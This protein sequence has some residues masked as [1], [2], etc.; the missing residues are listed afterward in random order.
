MQNR[1]KSFAVLAV[2]VLFLMGV[3]EVAGRVLPIQMGFGG[4]IKYLRFHSVLGSELDSNLEVLNHSNSCVDIKAI[5]I[6]QAGMRSA[7]EYSLVPI[8][9]GPRIALLGDSF[10][11]GREVSDGEEAAAAISR[12]LLE[13]DALNF[14]VPGYGSIQQLY[15]YELKARNYSPDIVVLAFLEVNDVED[16]SDIITAAAGWGS[17]RPMF[18]TEGE[19]I[20]PDPN[21]WSLMMG[22]SSGGDLHY[23]L[24][25]YSYIYFIL[26]KV[27]MRVRRVANR[28]WGVGAPSQEASIYEDYW[29]AKDNVLMHSGVYQS[30]PDPV[31]QQAWNDTELAIE[32]L[33]QMVTEDGRKFVLMLLPSTGSSYSALL[34]GLYADVIGE[35]IPDDI[36]LMYPRNRLRHFTTAQGIEFLDL[37]ENFDRYHEINQLLLPSFYYMCDGHFSPLGHYV[38]AHSLLDRLLEKGWVSEDDMANPEQYKSDDYLQVSPEELL[39]PEAMDTIYNWARVYEGGSRASER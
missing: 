8:K 27:I 9:N 39:G 18:D 23:S 32:R 25:R 13:G 16:N 7:S 36:D 6:N 11:M 1:S 4:N 34:P 38:V 21:A 3:L 24:R 37:N 33:N 10:I 31:W 5:A 28:T 12:Q 14:G 20:P 17:L 35:E 30:P 15:T 29:W 19:L 22:R 2:V 26:D